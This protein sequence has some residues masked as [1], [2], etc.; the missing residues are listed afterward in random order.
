MR[1]ES[2][3]RARRDGGRKLLVVYLTGGLDPAWLSPA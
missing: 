2:T 1:L 3:L